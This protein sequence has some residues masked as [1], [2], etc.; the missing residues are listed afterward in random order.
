MPLSM[1]PADSMWLLAESREHPM[2]VGGLQLFE[3]PEG[4]DAATVRAL[5]DT[6]LSNDTAAQRFRQRAT[7]SWSSLGQW[8]WEEDRGF[9]LGYHVRHD[10]LPQPGGMRELLDLCSQL[11]AAPL[12]R[13]RP[14]WEMHLIEGL[15]DGRF[16][17]YTKFHHAFA[18]G[19]S[20]MRLLARSL[21]E[22]PTD[23][24]MPAVWDMANP[25][26]ERPAAEEPAAETGDNGG[27]LGLPVAAVRGAATLLEGAAGLGSALA[28]TVARALREQGGSLSFA[29]PNTVLN[30]PIAGARRYAAQSWPIERL[31]LIAKASDATVND[32][33]LAMCSGGL[34]TYLLSQEALPEVPL[35]AAVPVSLRGGPD[36]SPAG[37]SFGVLMC[38]LATHSA[39]PAQR[40]E[41]VR[42]S[43]LEGKESL[44]GK[45]PSQILAM[46]AVGMVPAALHVVAGSSGAVRPPFNVVISNVPGPTTPLYW[47]GARLDGLY[48]IAFPQDGQALNITCTSSD[49]AIAF[50]LTGC[51]RALPDLDAI[52]GHLDAELQAL[53]TAVG[54]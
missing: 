52:L 49:D 29:A 30:V 47:N 51:R 54:I 27:I 35:I 9:D 1:S 7:R 19:V 15:N 32:V 53:E 50:G 36:E 10:A 48:P 5:F 23:R 28:G 6:A 4:G 45:R 11:H 16:A 17:V 24:A 31:R 41:T 38:N 39:D 37:N 14:L 33:V 2:H 21:S 26:P 44:T 43:M 12:D 34:R 40:L 13:H 25:E 20:A 42:A 18:D 22:D 46:S 3:P 8:E